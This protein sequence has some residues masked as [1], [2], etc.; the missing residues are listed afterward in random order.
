MI[1]KVKFAKINLKF[2]LSESLYTIYT[3]SFG[4]GVKIKYLK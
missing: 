3:S 1:I 4:S 2:E